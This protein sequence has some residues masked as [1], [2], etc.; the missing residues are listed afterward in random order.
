MS[1]MLALA[2]LL[3]AAVP[4][5]GAQP[6]SAPVVEAKGASFPSLFVVDTRGSAGRAPDTLYRAPVTNFFD[7]TLVGATNPR[8]FAIDTSVDA[9]VLYGAVSITSP[10]NT[11]TFGTI[12]PSTGAYTPI[13]PLN[14]VAGDVGGLAVHPV[15]G[16]IYLASTSGADSLLNVVNPSTGAATAIGG[17]V[18]AGAAT[19][20]AALAIDCAG[21]MFGF[22][23]TTDAIVRINPATALAITVGSTGI[24]ANGGQS[25]DFDGV[26][27][28][29]YAWLHVSAGQIVFGS[30]NTAT[31][32]VTPLTNGPDGTYEGA[33]P[34]ACPPETP[35]FANGFE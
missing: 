12:D 7:Q 27:G 16:T 26:S 5:A 9:S 35:I 33:V 30:V 6:A 28:T 14:L 10:A 20:V 13:G 17:I 19:D 31:G 2:T 11:G 3:S 15:T 8:V 29:L 34:T 24:A 23:R 1:A 4:L 21:R 25:L 18:N 22:D 32:A